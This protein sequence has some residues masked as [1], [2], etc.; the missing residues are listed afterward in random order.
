MSSRGKYKKI[1]VHSIKDLCVLYVNFDRV[2]ECRDDTTGFKFTIV[3]E[4]MR[5]KR[6]GIELESVVI[7]KDRSESGD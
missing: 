4:T 2:S 6:V 1:Q 3:R 5:D 7:T